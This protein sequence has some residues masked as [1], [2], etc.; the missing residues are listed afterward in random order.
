[1]WAFVINTW[2]INDRRRP[3]K[4][5]EGVRAREEVLDI[6]ISLQRYVTLAK[7]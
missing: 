5:L 3:N 7:A 1:M 4:V 2:S 6:V